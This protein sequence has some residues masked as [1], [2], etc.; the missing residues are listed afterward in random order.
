MTTKRKLKLKS[1]IIGILKVIGILLLIV[2]GCFI[3]YRKQI[4]DLKKIGYSELASKNILLKWKKE[5][6]LEVGKNKT[7]N[8]A[9]ESDDYK[10][11]NF[12]SYSKIK[13]KDPKYLIENINTLLKRGYNNEQITMILYHGSGEDVK[14]FAKRDKVRYLEEFYTIDY[15]KIKYYDRYVKY[16][17]ESREDEETSILLVNL[18]MD[19]EEYKDPVIVKDFSYEMLVNK[20]R[21]LEKDFKPNNLVKISEEDASEE[22]MMA[23]RTAYV[24]F[25]QMKKQ[26]ES[27]GYH[28]I[29]NSAYRDYDDQ[30]KIM[31]TYKK[32]YG[33]GYVEKYVL[34]P[35]FSEH[36]T[37]LA[38]DIGS[39]DTKVF[40]NSDEY[41]WITD[42]CYKFGFIYRFKKE[43][44]DI[45]GIRHEAWHYRYVGRKIAKEVYEKKLSYEEYYAM[46]IEK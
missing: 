36:Q 6:V 7:L 34:K 37:G 25:K 22:D 5:D 19:K 27:E 26:A 14:E 30:K 35:G 42:N 46:H 13:Y 8:V 9:F 23:N 4:N 17:D 32:L 15:A 21:Q 43:Y 39:T 31:E 3:L 20:H 11:K 33:D 16:M 2:L 45:T 18:D 24:A 1:P 38:F 29:I 10:E 44:E 28:L 12:D 40:A 41:T